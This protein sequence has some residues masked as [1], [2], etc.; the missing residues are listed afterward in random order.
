MKIR[1]ITGI[2]LLCAF[3][4]LC[5]GQSTKG[6]PKDTSYNIGRVY[7]QIKKNFPYAI[8]VPDS[9]PK[10]VKEYRNLVYASLP[11]SVHEKRDLHL[12]IFRPNNA[13]ILP[14][15]IMIH[16]GG[17]R[18][19]DKLMEVPMAQ[20]IAPHGFVTVPIEYQLSL[21]APFPAAVHN[22]KA[23]I[24]WL[25]ANAHEYRIDTNKIAISGTSAGG[26][27]AALVGTTNGITQFEGKMDNLNNSSNVQ[28]IIDIDGVINFLSPSSLNLKRKPDSPDIAWLGGSYLQKPETWRQASAGYWANDK[29]VPMLFINSGFSRFHAGQ[30]ELIGSLKEW[31]IYHEVYKFNVKIHPFW[32]FH[33]WADETANYMVSF[34]QKVFTK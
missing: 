33:P 12:D 24:R 13:A 7:S 11:N 14:A 34:M 18:S 22:I 19:G 2:W 16:G 15:L 27:L 4:L 10:G 1:F 3:N 5:Y 28:A 29:T 8:P 32:L 31:G 30:D 17:W 6:F 21:E 26:Q 23:A 25:K 9:L 20:L